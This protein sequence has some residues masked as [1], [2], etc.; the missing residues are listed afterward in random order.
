MILNLG[1]FAST[2]TS[3]VLAGSVTWKPAIIYRPGQPVTGIHLGQTGSPITITRDSRLLDAFIGYSTSVY[4]IFYG[5]PNIRE[6]SSMHRLIPDSVRSLSNGSKFD[7]LTVPYFVVEAFEWI[8]DPTSTLSSTQL[9]SANVTNSTGPRVMNL[10]KWGLIPDETW[11]PTEDAFPA[12]HTVSESRFLVI[13]TGPQRSGNC[14]LNPTIPSDVRPYLAT[15]FG[16]P[17]CFVFANV[18]YQAGAARCQRCQVSG[19]GVI[20]DLGDVKSLKLVEDSATSSALAIAPYVST[21]SLLIAYALPLAPGYPT[22]QDRS[23]EMLSRSYQVAWNSLTSLYGLNEEGSNVSIALDASTAS[24]LMW[25]VALWGG[26]HTIIVGFGVLFRYIHTRG[27]YPWIEDPVT[28]ALLVDPTTVLND[29]RQWAGEITPHGACV[30]KLEQD[31]GKGLYLV[32]EDA[33]EEGSV[34][35]EW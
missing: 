13:W 16:L 9:A 19:M 8:K 6:S 10:L 4:S 31:E 15:L 7:E 18:T 20:Q 35:E 33:K 28:A 11:G 3:S 22:Y 27:N 34:S 24:V 30:L 1:I 2:Y 12:P 23:I 14:T 26:L 5:D 25:R 17:S 21:T 29:S 32:L